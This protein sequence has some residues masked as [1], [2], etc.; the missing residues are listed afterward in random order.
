[1]SL[2]ESL[3]KLM[4]D[5]E[6]TAVD[7]AMALLD[8]K[9]AIMTTDIKNPGVMNALG[10][11]IAHYGNPDANNKSYSPKSAL[12]MKA[13]YDLNILHNISHKR[14]RAEEI[15]KIFTG[16]QLFLGMGQGQEQGGSG[17]MGKKGR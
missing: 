3:S 8:P 10:I 2:E 6:P 12:V 13:L 16:L 15:V 4:Q 11:Y 1:M 7:V 5:D 14:R 9:K 17:L